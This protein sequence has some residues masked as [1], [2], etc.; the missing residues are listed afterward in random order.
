MIVEIFGIE[1]VGRV[2][3]CFDFISVLSFWAVFSKRSFLFVTSVG[4][5]EVLC[6][7]L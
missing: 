7:S 1:K 5:G 3:S 4:V 6:L 2:G